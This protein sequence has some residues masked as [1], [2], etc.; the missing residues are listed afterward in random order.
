MKINTEPLE[1]KNHIYDHYKRVTMQ[2]QTALPN[3]A[4]IFIQKFQAH[5]RK[6]FK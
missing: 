6:F 4:V 3:L 2:A 5:I 1:V